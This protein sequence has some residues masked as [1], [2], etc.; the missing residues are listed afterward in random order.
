MANQALSSEIR[1][2]ADP[3]G[4]I[5]LELWAEGSRLA[6]AAASKQ[7]LEQMRACL[8][9]EPAQVAAELQAALVAYLRNQLATVEVSEPIEDPKKKLRFASKFTLR[10][11]DL[12]EPGVVWYDVTESTTGPD[13]LPAIV[14]N[15]MRHEVHRKLTDP[16]SVAR[17]LLGPAK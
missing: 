14:K 10:S 12:I 17:E 7:I 15:K 6:R 13:S 9:L 4:G 5:A 1:E 8:G 2:V 3:A 16:G 11:G